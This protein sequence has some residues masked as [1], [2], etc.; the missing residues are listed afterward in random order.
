MGLKV[1]LKRAYAERHNFPVKTPD[2]PEKGYR[3]R[4]NIS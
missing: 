1:S 3:I 2:S 4:L